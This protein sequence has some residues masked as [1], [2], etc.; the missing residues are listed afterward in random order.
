MITGNALIITHIIYI[1]VI[2]LGI[3]FIKKFRKDLKRI[4]NS[5]LK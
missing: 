1:L 4:K 5:L 2:I 3:I